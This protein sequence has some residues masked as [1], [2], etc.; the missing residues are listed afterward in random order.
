MSAGFN[1]RWEARGQ[2]ILGP[3]A[4]APKVMGIVN[5]TPDSFSDGGRIANPAEAV[6]FARRLAAQG[7]D[8]LDLGGESSRPGAAPVSLEDEL[9]RVL[10]VVLELS[11]SI[12]IPISV[13]TT[14]ASVARA[15]LAAGASI[16]NDISAL[17][18]DPEMAALAA[19]SGAGVVLMHMQGA[20][21]TMQKSPHYG[22]VVTEVSDFLARRVEWAEGRGI[23]RERIAI[24]PGIGFGKTRDHNLAILRNL[25]RFANLGC[26]VMIGVSRKGL[27][28]SITGRPVSERARQAWPQRSRLASAAPEWFGCMTSQRQPTRFASGPPSADGR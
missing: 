11:G 14:K 3:T 23:P 20:P 13:D 1:C 18:S 25:E 26:A 4:P 22:D 15:A 28:G 10:P 9:A 7:A 2:V 16:I 24:D 5:L 21:A 27:L 17:A 6:A 19:D 12:S 8:L